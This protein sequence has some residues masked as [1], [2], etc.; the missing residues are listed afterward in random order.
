MF[1]R[2][3]II[4]LLRLILVSVIVGIACGL[5]GSLFH[6]ALHFAA[7]VFHIN[8]WFIWFII[9][10]GLLVVSI[11]KILK[12]DTGYSTGSVIKD[13][14][15]DK[16]LPIG[17]SGSIF[18]STFITHI[19]G[20]SSGRE[21]AALQLGGC[22]GDIF[23]GI[24]FFKIEKEYRNFITMC[25]MSGLF[26]ALFGTPFAAAMFV[27]SIIN[28]R[29]FYILAT[30][31]CLISSYIAYFVAKGLGNAGVHYSINIPEV[32]F[33]LVWKLAIVAMAC[34]VMSIV[35]CYSIEYTKKFA[36]LIKNEY[37]RIAIGG[38]AV[39][40]LTFALGTNDYNGAG[41]NIIDN[42]IGGQTRPEAFL[43]K[44][45]FTAITLSFGYKGG[46]IVP[47][48][49]VGST[50]GCTLGVL[51]GID[52]GF[53]AAI[54]MMGV[55]C[56]VTKCPL[57]T[58]ILS[59]E[60]FGIDKILFFIPVCAIA[61]IFSGKESLYGRKEIILSLPSKKVKIIK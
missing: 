60:I 26:A 57:A 59:A 53:A 30:I 2:E 17:L 21:G 35:F 5:V 23:S 36:K 61:F 37:I 20:G 27:L 48:F 33:E 34:A 50:L 8:P 13:V 25:G 38:L 51:L 15:N 11:Y 42:A 44:I 6:Y 7:E 3:K 28:I 54:G 56:G 9:P 55:F 16:Q 1:K 14:R 18:L 32:N 12:V 45:L 39:M 41:A 22:V 58:I 43:L 4:V 47:S 29:S 40:I 19:F 52:P 10:G 46:E 24:S 31:P 49:F